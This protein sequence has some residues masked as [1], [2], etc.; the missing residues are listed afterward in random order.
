MKPHFAEK[1]A[2]TINSQNPMT[3]IQRSPESKIDDFLFEIGH[4]IKLLAPDSDQGRIKNLLN[5][6]CGNSLHN[7]VLHPFYSKIYSLDLLEEMIQKS[8]TICKNISNVEYLIDYAQNAHKRIEPKTIDDVLMINLASLVPHQNDFYEIFESLK[9]ILKPHGKIVIGHVPHL[10][11]KESYLSQLPAILRKKN[12]NE[13]QIEK[14]LQ[15]NAAINYY[16]PIEMHKKLSEIGFKKFHFLP[17]HV[18]HV[19]HEA[20]FDAVIKFD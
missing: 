17:S 2:S 19:G 10:E 6:A 15:D 13:T 14:I 3:Q 4:F 1:I 12:F 5:V 9:K 20:Q 16:S 8:K 7:L 18:Q 11:K